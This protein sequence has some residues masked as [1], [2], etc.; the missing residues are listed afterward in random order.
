MQFKELKD[1]FES[2]LSHNITVAKNIRKA[3]ESHVHSQFTQ[4]I[5]L[6]IYFYVADS[7]LDFLPIWEHTGNW[8]L[9]NANL[10]NS[11]LLKP[12][13]SKGQYQY[14]NH[15]H[16]HGLSDFL[17]YLLLKKHVVNNFSNNRAI[18]FPIIY[19]IVT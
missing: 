7:E 11:Y 9:E 10:D 13:D 5:Y 19:Q 1:M 12:I 16:W 2:N 6:L 3:G 14:I 15:C 18:A 4:G 17:P 8:F